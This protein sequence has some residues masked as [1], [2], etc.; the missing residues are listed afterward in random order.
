[1]LNHTSVNIELLKE[2]TVQ[3]TC[4]IR[5]LLA[6]RQQNFN[7]LQHFFNSMIAVS[8]LKKNEVAIFSLYLRNISVR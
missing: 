5:S 7:V 8:R 3:Y 4:S 1:M 6:N 2:V